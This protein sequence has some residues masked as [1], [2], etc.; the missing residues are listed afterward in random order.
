MKQL[1]LISHLLPLFAMM[2]AAA[3]VVYSGPRNL[4]VTYDFGGLYL[5]PA[6]GSTTPNEAIE[7]MINLF[8]GGVGIGTNDLLRPVISGGDQVAN[9]AT[10][11]MVDGNNG[12][13]V[14]YNG[15]SSHVGPALDQYQIGIP[16]NLGFAM[17]TTLGG[18]TYYGWMQVVINNTGAGTVVDWAYENTSDTAIAVGAIPEAESMMLVMLGAA[19]I[20]LRRPNRQPEGANRRHPR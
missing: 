7:P 10:G 11:A 15:S 9:L 16:G 14:G 1:T 17:Q 19:G 4:S 12:F 8:F 18:P 6:T 5:N 20:I 2:P 13:A 3:A